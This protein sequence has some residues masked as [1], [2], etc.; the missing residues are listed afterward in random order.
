[1]LGMGGNWCSAFSAA[2]AG[3]TSGKTAWNSDFLGSRHKPSNPAEAATAGT[4][5]HES[6]AQL[7]AVLGAPG[8]APGGLLCGVWVTAA[9]DVSCFSDL[10]CIFV[11]SAVIWGAGWRRTQWPK[12]RLGDKETMVGDRRERCPT[13]SWT[14][15]Q[16]E[17]SEAGDERLN[18][19]IK[20]LALALHEQTLLVLFCRLGKLRSRLLGSQLTCGFC[21][22]L[23]STFS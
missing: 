21:I 12:C 17:K 6:W 10:G 9:T 8:T 14:H 5:V 4:A 16:E 2:A 7:A 13:W 15:G 3:S 18:G 22:S 11:G 1:M 19:I 20:P 23:R